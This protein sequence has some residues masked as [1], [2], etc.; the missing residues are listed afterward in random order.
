MTTTSSPPIDKPRELRRR[1]REEETVAEGES[2]PKRRRIT[3]PPPSLT[4]TASVPVVVPEAVPR[5]TT[6]QPE[7]A[8][9][10]KTAEAVVP[11]QEQQEHEKSAP[12][13]AGKSASPH[14]P[15]PES[16]KPAQQ[17]PSDEDPSA[18]GA[19]ACVMATPRKIGIQHIQL[20]YETVGQTLQCRMCMYDETFIFLSPLYLTFLCP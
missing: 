8:E 1:E 10:S 14:E 6:P 19:V 4:P 7:V 16:P 2:A 20:V 5:P 3:P 13:L 18:A 11:A 15:G 17:E 12:E 9:S